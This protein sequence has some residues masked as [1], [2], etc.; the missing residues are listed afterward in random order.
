MTTIASI[1][2]DLIAGLI[3]GMWKAIPGLSAITDKITSSLKSA[4]STVGGWFTGG[5]GEETTPGLPPPPA[6]GPRLNP[7]AAGTQRVELNTKIGLVLP[8]GVSAKVLSSEQSGP[9][10]VEVGANGAGVG[11]R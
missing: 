11:A 1:G 6:R 5:D 2:Y 9:G 4:A 7:A 8:P 3:S 10:N